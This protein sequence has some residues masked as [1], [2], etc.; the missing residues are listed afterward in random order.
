MWR[1][2]RRRWALMLLE[3]TMLTLRDDYTQQGKA[4]LFAALKPTL[5]EEPDAASATETGERL[6]M[7]AGAVRV[8][9]TR[10]RARY[11]RSLLTEVAASMDAQTEAE[12]DEEIAALFRAVI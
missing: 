12:V 7:T 2:Y 5:T 10:P 4:D 11:R 9:V 3:R 8:A 6:G 1:L